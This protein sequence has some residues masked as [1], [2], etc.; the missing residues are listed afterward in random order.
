MTCGDGS[1]YFALPGGDSRSPT[2]W[3]RPGARAWGAAET[4]AAGEPGELEPGRLAPGPGGGSGLTSARSH[5]APP[6]SRQ[7]RGLRHRS[8]CG[9]V[10]VRGL[11]RQER[12]PDPDG[13]RDGGEGDQPG[14][15]LLQDRGPRHGDHEDSVPC[16]A[17]L[18]PLCSGN[19][20]ARLTSWRVLLERSKPTTCSARSRFVLCFFQRSSRA[21]REQGSRRARAGERWGACAAR[22]RLLSPSG[23]L[24]CSWSHRPAP[25]WR[26]RTVC[27]AGSGIPTPRGTAQL[28]GDPPGG[29]DAPPR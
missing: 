19:T 3:R 21:P 26:S 8:R 16:A 15:H 23:P 18:R 20:A 14:Q 5:P 25:R 28:P 12:C 17:G 22:A 1:H 9:P 13:D 6:L 27:A 2:A 24:H 11:I 4:V 29:T 10:L 7:G